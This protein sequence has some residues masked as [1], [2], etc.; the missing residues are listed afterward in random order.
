MK[1]FSLFLT[2]L[3]ACFTLPLLAQ[4][5]QALSDL[6]PVRSEKFVQGFA[7][8][9]DGERLD[10]LPNL[11]PGNIALYLRATG[12]RIEFETDPMPERSGA[13]VTFLWE[14]AVARTT[15]DN[16][17]PFELE[18]NGEKWFTFETAKGAGDK[19]WIYAGPRGSELAFVTSFAD[20][21]KGD[22]FGYMF[23]TLPRDIAP[24]GAPLKI[25]LSARP[26]AGPEWYMAFQNRVYPRSEAYSAPALIR[27]GAVLRQPLYV[28]YL[29][30]GAPVEAAIL[31]NGEKRREFMLQ[32]GENKLRLLVDRVGAPADVRVDIVLPQGG[33]THQVRLKPVREFE[34]YLLPHSH[35]D[36][37]FTHKQAEVERMQ[38]RNFEQGIELARQTADYPEGAQY[39]WN[40][41]V[42][43]AVDGYLKHA[44]PEKREAFL[45][46]V[47][48]GWIGLDALYGSELTALQRPEELMQSF[49][50]ANRLEAEYGIPIRSAMITDVPGY[51]WGIVPA[52]AQNDVRYFSIGPNHMPHLAH[53]GYQVGYTFEAWGDVPFYWESPSGKEKV[54]FWMTRHGYSWFHDWL[55]G[56]LRKSGG[57]P[58]LQFLEELDEEGYP[59]DIVQL[60]Y[61]LGDNGGPDAD[62]P[63]FVREWN[64]KY[65]YPKLRI[66]TTMEMFSAF[67]Q[68][69][70]AELP[71]Y[72]GD[73]TPYWEDGA[74][75]SAVETAASRNAAEQ[76]VQ[77]ESMWAMLRPEEFPAAAFDEAWTNVVLFS[78]HTWG[79]ITSKSDPDGEL[80]V[81][82][83]QVKQGFA[84]D[85]ARQAK[86]LSDK[87]A[88]ALRPPSGPVRAFL[89]FNTTSW[90]RTELVKLPAGWSLS[91][92]A[93][94]G[95][96]GK[97]LATQELSTGE[98]AFLAKDLP[99]LSA[100]RF[101]LRPNKA[102]PPKEK[103]AVSGSSLSNGSLS[104]QLDERTGGIKSIRFRGLP[105]D[106]VDS[107]SAYGFNEYWYTGLDA[108]SPQRSSKPKIRIGEKG[109]LL[110]SLIVESEAPGAHSLKREIE[111]AAGLDYFRLANTVDKIKVLEDENVRFSFPFQVP[112]GQAR[113][114]LAWA[115][116]R[117]EQDQLKGANKN[118]FCP[119]HWV[120]F[121][122]DSGGLTWANPD[123]P[124]AELGGM[125]G[126][127]WMSD[128]RT[129]PWI[130]TF[131]PSSLLFSW[132]MNNA[133]FVNYKG[134][135]EGPARFRYAIRPHRGFDSTE[136]KKF[137]IAQSQPLIAVPVDDGQPGIPALFTLD[138]GQA[139]IATSCRPARDGR[140]WVV[141]L[142]NT[143]GRESTA[144][145]KWGR[146]KPPAIYRSNPKE[147]L[148][149]P[150]GPEISLGAWE[151]LTLRVLP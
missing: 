97:A 96:D 58:I 109:P 7:K 99:P 90:P 70:G 120:D 98:L 107:T 66:A 49:G 30:L 149:E 15:G 86:E 56:K 135:Q 50:F 112:G 147:I 10:F 2:T 114:D 61:T 71:T 108:A 126:Q 51:A 36:I 84:L 59:Y 145:L 57:E 45:D 103:V 16:P 77:A 138:G 100:A 74:A 37:G 28:E 130:K 60:R 13:M 18:V 127:N 117:P 111:L 137:G 38:W 24:A 72:G 131:Q 1:Y 139:V 133:W 102:K 21:E 73:F 20:P 52:L 23:L 94:V 118:F 88:A 140:G 119:Q 65:A 113:I 62:M 92:L 87:A 22:L 3:L 123:A 4:D 6:W 122:N 75:S 151:I 128:L 82:Q 8:P 43:W 79:S 115:V 116:M 64:E 46:A 34:V 106:L 148:G 124:L 26:G 150:A 101:T 14:A 134:Y 91:G 81:S 121:S 55:L 32:P 35:V 129:R 63:D 104:V 41:E 136:A 144:V 19:H 142:F 25:G 44:S 48:R 68:R 11:Q 141:R 76:L 53:G 132:V 40:A 89:L 27:D 93:V 95:P 125:Y 42:L 33:S 17:I 78:E 29:H 39:R 54:L 85:A 146:G 12:G 69:Y 5:K 80:A 67:E 110:A 9:L 31:V 143:S 105:F 83:W 47:R